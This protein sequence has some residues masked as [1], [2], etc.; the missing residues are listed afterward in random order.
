M[1]RPRRKLI[2]NLTLAC[3]STLLCLLVAEIG[4]RLIYSN[5]A[6]VTLDELEK[7]RRRLKSHETSMGDMLMGS[8]NPRLV[9]QLIPNLDVLWSGHRVRTNSAGWRD[10]EFTTP[11]PDGVV[12]IA[13]LGDSVTF[14]WLVDAEERYTEALESV[15]NRFSLGPKFEVLNFGIPGYNSAMELELLTRHV[16]TLQPDVV[17]LQFEANDVELPVFLLRRETYWTLNR[18]YLWEFLRSRRFRRKSPRHDWEAAAGLERT[19]FQ[20]DEHGTLLSYGN[21]DRIPPELRNMVGEANCR[22]AIR[23]IGAVCR[24][25]SIPAVF[26]LNPAMF[27]AC[28]ETTPTAKLP[29][30]APFA[31]AARQ[32]GF[33]IADP[34]SFGLEFLRSQ[35]IGSFD[36]FVDLLT[37]DPHPSPPKHTLLAMEIA[38]AMIEQNL[39]PSGSIDAQRLPEILAAFRDRAA[40]QWSQSRRAAAPKISA[41]AMKLYPLDAGAKPVCFGKGWYTQEVHLTPVDFT[42]S[43]PEAELLVPKCTRLVIEVE[44]SP[45]QPLG[46]P[47]QRFFLGSWELKYRLT[48]GGRRA[49]FDISVPADAIASGSAPL[50]LALRCRP[51]DR[52]DLPP[53]ETRELGIAVFSIFVEPLQ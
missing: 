13:A 17:L 45:V 21:E 16:L 25:H 38:R 24:Q 14:G 43:Q 41:G 1:R 7:H 3:V 23:D 44:F 28:S 48:Q 34:A 37:N 50:T 4:L 2:V 18:C 20:R 8:Q 40:T 6:P 53:L 5:Q 42:W 47:H 35:G 52:A 12:R 30:Y 19:M 26:L 15:L 9:Y 31:T 22:K 46:P 49:W 33:V 29:P 32:S 39:L 27:E 11:K 10:E 51:L 36:L